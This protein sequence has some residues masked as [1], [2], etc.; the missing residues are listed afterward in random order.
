VDLAV[1]FVEHGVAG[2]FVV[3]NHGYVAS[4]A[5]LKNRPCSLCGAVGSFVKET[6]VEHCI[7]L[8]QILFL[9]LGLDVS[10]MAVRLDV[11]A[12]GFI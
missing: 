6:A 10:E 3:S 11:K 5:A 9:L 12:I 1:E 2:P 7:I 4:G 8:H